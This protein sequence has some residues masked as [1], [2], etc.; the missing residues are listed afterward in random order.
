MNNI[1]SS[2][3]KNVN[4]VHFYEVNTENKPS[5]LMLIIQSANIS[6]SGFVVCAG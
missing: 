2:Q 3:Y 6:S 5:N 4:E 1:Y